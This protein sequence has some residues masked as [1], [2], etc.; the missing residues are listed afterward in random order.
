V[1]IPSAFDSSI[2]NLRVGWSD[3]ETQSSDFD[4]IFLRDKFPFIPCPNASLVD[5]RYDMVALTKNTEPFELYTAKNTDIDNCTEIACG[6]FKNISRYFRDEKLT[7]KAPEVFRQWITN[8]H[9]RGELYMYGDNGFISVSHTDKIM[10]ID[11][12]AV[13]EKTRGEGVGQC[14]VKG[15]FALPG[16]LER[17]VRVE[18][19][20]IKAIGFYL[21][22]GF[23]IDSVESVQH[24][25]QLSGRIK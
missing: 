21:L 6:G 15:F 24:I 17:R 7:D 23:R 9:N 10:R 8:A 19:G 20:N 18:V 12:I 16:Q 4:L 14:L 13:R 5:V 3:Q 22:S 25:W 2:Y 11:L 1:I